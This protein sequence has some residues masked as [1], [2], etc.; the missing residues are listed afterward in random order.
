M[1]PSYYSVVRAR[2]NLIQSGE[3]ITVE[4]IQAVLGVRFYKPAIA[5]RL[6]QIEDII[7]RPILLSSDSQDY[8]ERAAVKNLR[9]ILSGMS[10]VD[11][12]GELE[13]LMMY[14]IPEMEL[15]RSVLEREVKGRS[16]ANCSTAPKH[17]ADEKA[18][19]LAEAS[20]RYSVR[21]TSVIRI[22]SN[23]VSKNPIC[24]SCTNCGLVMEISYL[25]EMAPNSNNSTELECKVRSLEYDLYRSNQRADELGNRLMK[26]HRQQIQL[27][28]RAE[29]LDSIV[30]AI[31][32]LNG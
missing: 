2:A 29:M 23:A 6:K 28:Y 11:L 3:K 20:L 19:L 12:A 8:G 25:D 26:L 13:R 21:Q 22:G 27:Q 24:Y 16:S 17:T 10:K 7:R 4:N 1:I 30:H 15:R 31:R 14:V 18:K 32:K 5:I 9:K